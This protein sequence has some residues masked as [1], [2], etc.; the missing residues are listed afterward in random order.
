MLLGLVESLLTLL[1]PLTDELIRV[2]P[3]IK[4]RD[5][6]YLHQWL[7]MQFKLAQPRLENIQEQQHTM[8]L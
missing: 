7:I 6:G 1:E 8:T 4:C 5:V 3:W 2:M